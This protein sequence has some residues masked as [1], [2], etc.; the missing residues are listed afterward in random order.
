MARLREL[1]KSRLGATGGTIAGSAPPAVSDPIRMP[2]PG[3]PVALERSRRRMELYSRRGG[4]MS[5]ILSDNLKNM[6][7]G[8]SGG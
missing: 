8:V 4:R 1:R 5:T 3:D 7:R 2:D 6:L